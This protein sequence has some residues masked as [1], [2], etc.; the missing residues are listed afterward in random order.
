MS[1]EHPNGDQV[2]AVKAPKQKIQPWKNNWPPRNTESLQYGWMT[3]F[4]REQNM[5]K[6][7]P[8]GIP[9]GELVLITASS[10][11]AFVQIK[12]ID[13]PPETESPNARTESENAR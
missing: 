8:Q 12:I 4:E 9:Q 3:S 6:P 10:H 13:P 2:K 7:P 5:P 11:P 1:K